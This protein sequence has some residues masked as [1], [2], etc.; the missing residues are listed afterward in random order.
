MSQDKP[1]KL[2][3]QISEEAAE[4]LVEFRTGAM[5]GEARRAFDTWVRSS[6]EHLRAYLEIAAIW[7]EGSALDAAHEIDIHAFTHRVH[8]ECNVVPFDASSVERRVTEDESATPAGDVSS[9]GA[10]AGL[11]VQAS[12]SDATPKKVVRGSADSTKQAP[13]VFSR[14]FAVAASIVF[15]SLALGAIVWFQSSQSS[16]YRTAVGEQRT[17]TLSDG[18]TVALNSRSTIRVRFANHERD[19]DLLEGQAL[20]HVAKDHAR[21]FIVT[22]DGTRVRAV[23]TQFDVYR[24]GEST[25]VTVMEGRVAILRESFTQPDVADGLASGA[26]TATLSVSPVTDASNQV[27]P[28]VVYLSAGEQITVTAR[29]APKPVR[30]NVSAAIAWTQHQLVLESAPLNE[31]A[32]EFNRYSKRKLL[33]EESATHR[34]RLSGVFSTDPDFLIRYLRDRPDITVRETDSEVL[35]SHHD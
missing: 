16:T 8:A 19:V 33:V 26:A 4:W 21:P 15:V 35:I 9:E 24:K 29:A 18:S 14:R 23:G 1:I 2:N 32:D 27:L 10:G 17:L 31:V 25:V 6:P 30:A 13:T 7:N 11:S 3:A 22:S 28:D 20:F 5:D 12:T 34:L